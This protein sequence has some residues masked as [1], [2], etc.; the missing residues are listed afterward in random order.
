MLLTY[1]RNKHA[2]AIDL[3]EGGILARAG[4][5]ETFFAA[6]VELKISIPDLEITSIAGDIERCISDSCRHTVSLIQQAA[7]LR[8]GP[9]IIKLVN[10][11]VGNSRGC[12]RLADL[13]LECCEQVILRFTVDPL[14]A[15]LTLEGQEKVEAFKEFLRQN[16]R[17][18]NSCIAFAPGSPLREGVELDF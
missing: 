14:G 1:T 18:V 13:I 12:P 6:R 2:G 4:V 7:G 15:I 16:P 3:P 5:E 17:L 8:V 9:G 10:N 11:Y